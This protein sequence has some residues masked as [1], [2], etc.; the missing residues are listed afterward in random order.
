MAKAL[1]LDKLVNFFRSIKHNGGILGSLRTLYRVDE[2]KFGDLIGEDKYGN[3]YYENNMYFY[4][5]NRW[6]IYSPRVHMNYDA[7][8]VPAEW[9]GWLHYKT[10]LPPF[11]D[12][13]RPKYK[14]MVDHTPNLSGTNKAYMPYSTVKTKIEA[15]QPKD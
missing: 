3:K 15:W 11:K 9:Y 8:Q 2:L 5:R 7:S 14:W 6:V 13:S 10:D 12:P 4:G 1:G